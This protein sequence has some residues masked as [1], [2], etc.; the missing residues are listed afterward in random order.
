MYF[1]I[2]NLQAVKI[3]NEQGNFRYFVINLGEMLKYHQFFSDFI[4]KSC[5][6]QR[7]VMGEFNVE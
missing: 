1:I 2:N 7:E 5:I 6:I 3:D 4:I